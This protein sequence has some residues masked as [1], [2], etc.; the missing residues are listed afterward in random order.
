MNYG[1]LKATCRLD[2]IV[3]ADFDH[4]LIEKVCK[5]S[6]LSSQRAM[7]SC[8]PP[9]FLRTYSSGWRPEKSRQ[10]YQKVEGRPAAPWEAKRKGSKALQ[11]ASRGKKWLGMPIGLFQ[12]IP[13]RTCSKPV[14]GLL[15]SP[16]RA[17]CVATLRDLKGKV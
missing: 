17:R 10:Q 3:F 12:G 9:S 5:A 11:K 1:P 13:G 4:F 7:Y 16:V 6:Y 2:V 8:A 14:Q 15:N